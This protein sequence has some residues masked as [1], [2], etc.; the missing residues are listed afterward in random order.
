MRVTE[1]ALDL[2]QKELALATDRFRN[3]LSDNIEVITAQSSVA[4]AEQDRI[5]AL[6]RHADARMALGARDGRE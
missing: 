1:Q 6:A 2:A 3:G 5:E 4:E